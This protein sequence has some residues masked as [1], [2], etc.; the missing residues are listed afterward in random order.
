LCSFPD[1]IVGRS[2]EETG[3]TTELVLETEV[4]AEDV[5]LIDDE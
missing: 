4:M 1:V 2:E 5:V 3:W